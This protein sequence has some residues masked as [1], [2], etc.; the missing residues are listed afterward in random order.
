M[1]PQQGKGYLLL[2]LLFFNMEELPFPR[3]PHGGR[4]RDVPPHVAD[5][6]LCRAVP[7]EW[8][9]LPPEACQRWNASQR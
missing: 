7:R 8:R 1:L 5:D 6:V 3:P 9:P 4:R 2:E